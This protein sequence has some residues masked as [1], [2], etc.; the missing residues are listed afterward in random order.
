[1][2]WAFLA[3]V[4]AAG[5]TTLFNTID[6]KPIPFGVMVEPVQGAVFDDSTR[7]IEIEVSGFHESPGYAI[8][9]QVL[10]DPNDTAS[11]VTLETVTTRNEASSQ[12]SDTLY[13]WNGSISPTE[14][15]RRERWPSGGIIRVRAVGQD[16]EVLGGL[17][18]DA[19]GCIANRNL[20]TAWRQIA[21][22]CGGGLDAGVVLTSS[23]NSP[24]L[25]DQGRPLFLNEKGIGSANETAEYYQEIDA[26]LTATAFRTRFGFDN[27][28]EPVATYYNLG[29]LSVGREIRCRAFTDNTGPG[30]ACASANY[31]AFSG[32]QDQALALAITGTESGVSTG[33]FATVSMVYRP[34]ITAPNSVQFMVYGADGALVNEA[35]LDRPG[36]NPSI[37]HNCLNC[38]GTGSSYDANTNSVS[39][40]RFL[41]FDPLAFAF[42]DEN[43]YRRPDQEENIRALNQIVLGTEMSASAREFVEGMYAGALAT[44]GTIANEEFVPVGW[45][46]S[47]ETRA[48]Y[49]HA[50]APYCRGCHA[51]REPG[52][53]LDFASADA[54]RAWGPKIGEVMCSPLATHSMPSAEAVVRRF[55]ASPARAYLVEFLN[56]TGSCLAEAPETP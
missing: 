29:D 48:V 51:S 54:L 5:C 41:P 43:G 30:I 19:E 47:E 2:R 8:E 7:D 42:A 44:A 26:P 27:D 55:W 52:D 12:S 49:L 3:S 20:D 37:P 16:G 36:D 46:E 38:H 14:N 9:L 32:D 11:W 6:E 39:N 33:A 25:R 56:L 1:M 50:V 28:N 34:P 45:Q 31:G 15:D 35:E 13:A 40:A 4:W 53:G 10:D 21:V 24:E 23:R 22:E 17:H 18:V